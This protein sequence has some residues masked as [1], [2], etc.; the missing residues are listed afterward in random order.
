MTS[1]EIKHDK[2]KKTLNYK[3]A[4]LKVYDVPVLYFPKFFHPDPT[5]KRQSG[6][7]TPKFAQSSQS[8][9]L[10]LSANLKKDNIDLTFT[11]RVYTDDKIILQTEYRHLT[12][13]SNHVLDFSIKNKSPLDLLEQKTSSQSHFFSN[14][15]FKLNLDYFDQIKTNFTISTN[16]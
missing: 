10:S 2:I 1:S 7:L 11:P 14:S 8:L 9:S 6:F 12:K 5:V 13:N 16:F 15:S 4:W 3:N